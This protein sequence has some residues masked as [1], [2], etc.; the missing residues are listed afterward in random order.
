MLSVII[1]VV[2]APRLHNNI[3]QLFTHFRREMVLEKMLLLLLLFEISQLLEGGGKNS[4]RCRNCRHKSKLQVLP[5]PSR[6]VAVNHV[7]KSFLRASFQLSCERLREDQR[8]TSLSHSHCRRARAH[9]CV[10]CNITL[11]F[12]G[13]VV[14][15]AVLEA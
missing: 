1:E 7:I 10:C 8:A 4:S 13:F 12:L 5:L 2:G 3:Y 6:E 9:V 14:N 11:R 15:S